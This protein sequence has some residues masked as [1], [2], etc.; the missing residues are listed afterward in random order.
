MGKI[1]RGDILKKKYNKKSI[2]KLK[3]L[4]FS[5]ISAWILCGI[6]YYLYTSYK[7]IEIKESNYT[8]EKII[9]S[10]NYGQT[11]ED[12]EEN[13]TKV[14]DVIEKVTKCVCGISKLK[15]TGNTILSMAT[16]SE[17]GLGTGII[18]SS[19]GYVLSNSHVTG[20]KYS[21]CYVTV[22]DKNT[23]RGVVVWSD[24]ELDLSIVKIAAKNLNCVT[25]GS[26]E[27][28]RV[29]EKVYAIGN[30]IGYEFRR[31]VT[32]GIISATN[33]TIKIE[34]DDKT[35]YMSDLIQTDATINPG[36]S[37][38]PLIFANGEVIGVNSVKITSAEGI[39]FAIP[40]NVVKPII[41]SFV[42]T[43]NFEEATLGI[44]AYDYYVAQS[45]K[46]TT[47]FPSGVYVEQ[48]ISN[49]PAFKSGLIERDIITKID[50]KSVE[51]VNELKQYIYYK[52]PGDIV[53]LEVV[54]NKNT[55]YFEVVLERK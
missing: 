34:E 36:N 42:N 20:E 7:K 38:G 5:I 49:G 53:N 17:L 19:D 47:Q 15:T 28:A 14:A 46:L 37:G 26:S 50:G 39:G 54:R 44:Y 25:L 9:A 51:T 48:L 21:T 10:T 27:E 11:V 52:K 31:T 30:P 6:T 45:L 22:E 18:V 1:Y 3:S 12:E 29:G 16:E 35:I 40:I 13:N 55:K 23:Y 41:E 8:S 32:S 24:T 43:G 4:L 33:R 2:S